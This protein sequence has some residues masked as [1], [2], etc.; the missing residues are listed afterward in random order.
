MDYKFRKFKDP[1]SNQVIDI[2]NHYISNSFAA[3][4]EKTINYGAIKI[5]KEMTQG[6]P[7]FVVENGS[8]KVVGFAFIRPYNRTEVFNRVAE[9]TYFILPGH[10]RKG[11]GEKL[12]DMVIKEAKKLKIDSLLA[13]VSSLNEP[14]LEFHYKNGFIQCGC[15]KSIGKKFNRDF[16]MIWMQKKI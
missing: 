11:V 16:D 13:S 12:L 6:F 1:D 10:T 3:Y 4:S 15:F 9:I 2:F 7:F 8:G 14:S 5:F